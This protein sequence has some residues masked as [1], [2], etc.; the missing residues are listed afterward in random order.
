[1]SK[2]LKYLTIAAIAFVA[3]GLTAVNHGYAHGGSAPSLMMPS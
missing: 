3:V 1:M 2:M